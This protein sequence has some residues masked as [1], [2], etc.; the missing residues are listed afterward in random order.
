MD[1]TTNPKSA[2]AIV[3]MI[4][5]RRAKQQA[6]E[7]AWAYRLGHRM[8]TPKN[9]LQK[10]HGGFRRPPIEDNHTTT[11]QKKAAAMEGTI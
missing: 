6:R 9:K 5:G 4:E 11:N 2:E 7:R 3:G 8:G 10:I 1:T